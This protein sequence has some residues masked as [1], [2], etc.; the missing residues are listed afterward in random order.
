MK[1]AL[2]IGVDNFEKLVGEDYYYVYKSLL[3]KDLL[4]LKGEVN[5]FNRP[6]R[7]G[8]TLNLSMF[9]YF[10]ED[11]GDERQN[12]Q[13]KGLEN[14][15]KRNSAIDLAKFVMAVFVVAIHVRPFSGN[16]AFLVDDCITRLANPM[17][18]TISSYFLFYRLEKERVYKGSARWEGGLL[19][20]YVKRLLALYTVWFILNLPNVLRL[21]EFDG[22]MDLFVRFFQFYFL[23]GP[24]YTA[25]WFLPALLWG[26]LLT[27]WIGRAVRPEAALLAG[28]ALYSLAV[29]DGDYTVL[30]REVTWF[31]ALVDGFKKIFLWLANGFNYGL[32]YCALGA[33]AAV[34]NVR[35]G[36]RLQ[37][38]K[39]EYRARF[40]VW[41]LIFLGLYMAECLLIKWRQWGGGFGAQFMMVPFSYVCLQFLLLMEIKERPIYRFLQKMSIV[42]FGVQFLVI[43]GFRDLLAG[44]AWY[45]ESTTV[46]F[47]VVLGV[48]CAMAAVVVWLSEHI[49]LKFL[50]YLYQMGNDFRLYRR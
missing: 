39:R 15:G 48:T 29:L 30:M 1:K 42:I 37:E 27:F 40:G 26:V 18:F 6:R 32:V 31:Q 44:C 34:R 4:D 23:A 10:F 45:M 21:V 43:Y 19:R 14:R 16:L 25:L 13:N 12:A 5:L 22:T 47:A 33:C 36:G 20:K 8:K 35:R 17:F 3:I 2:P 38:R 50:K 46:Q 24:S 41:T 28:L 9:R 49:R 7:F 11:T